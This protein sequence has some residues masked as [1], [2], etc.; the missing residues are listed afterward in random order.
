MIRQD[1]MVRF[2][3]IGVSLVEAVSIAIFIASRLHVI[4]K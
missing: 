3:I 2:L 4:G 1:R